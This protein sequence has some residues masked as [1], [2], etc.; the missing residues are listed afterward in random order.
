MQKLTGDSLT[1]CGKIGSTATTIEEAKNDPKV[2]QTTV[3]AQTAVGC[4]LL[5]RSA[6]PVVLDTCNT[7]HLHDECSVSA[8]HFLGFLV[9]RPFARQVAET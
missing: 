6:Q 5:L 4:M 1:A 3:F 8:A 9:E 2:L 7:C